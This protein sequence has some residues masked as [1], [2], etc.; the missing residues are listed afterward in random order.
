MKTFKWGGWA[1]AGI[2]AVSLGAFTGCKKDET[3]SES[4]DRNSEKAKDSLKEAGEKTKDALKDAGDKTSD[5]LKKAGDKLKT[6][7]TSTNK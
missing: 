6:A 2:L 1:L 3:A 7:T 5:A 4:I